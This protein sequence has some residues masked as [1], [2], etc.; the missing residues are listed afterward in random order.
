MKMGIAFSFLYLVLGFV[1]FQL[2][3]RDGNLW[4]T[5]AASGFAIGSIRE[6]SRVLHQMLGA[7]DGQ[8]PDRG[9]DL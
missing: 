2:W 5:L 3:K 4:W 1:S 7:N 6:T 8:R 9:A